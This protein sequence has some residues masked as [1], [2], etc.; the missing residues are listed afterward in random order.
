[1]AKRLSPILRHL[2][3]AA[4]LGGQDYTQMVAIGYLEQQL[5]ATYDS[6]S[7]DM[8]SCAYRSI[9]LKLSTPSE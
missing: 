4:N 6:I 5:T 7:S 9:S 2:G 8:N 1:M 3:G